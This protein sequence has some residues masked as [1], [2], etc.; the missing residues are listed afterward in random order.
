MAKH[1]VKTMHIREML[2]K[3]EALALSAEH[4]MVNSEEG[5]II[6]L[7]RARGLALHAAAELEDELFLLRYGP[8]YD[9]EN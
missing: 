2:R 7:E 4:R 1:T 9:K 8:N 3:S 6:M 5:R